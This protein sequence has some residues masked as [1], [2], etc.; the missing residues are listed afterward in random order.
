VVIPFA[1][2][3]GVGSTTHVFMTGALEQ[4]EREQQRARKAAKA[5]ARQARALGTIQSELGAVHA[6]LHA[7]EESAG[8]S[9]GQG[10][11]ASNAAAM[12]PSKGAHRR[13]VYVPTA[14]DCSR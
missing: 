14:A 7:A 3:R 13:T 12:R 2:A 4:E 11:D 10:D 5:L 1:R 9:P 6:E 8:V